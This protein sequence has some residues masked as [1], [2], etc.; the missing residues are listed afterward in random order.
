MMPATLADA[1]DALDRCRADGPI[2]VLRTYE[3]AAAA[4]A[5][6]ATRPSRCTSPPVLRCKG[7]NTPMRSNWLGGGAARSVTIARCTWL[8]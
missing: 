4:R 5:A 2:D 6:R 1:F 8:D 7:S 3:A